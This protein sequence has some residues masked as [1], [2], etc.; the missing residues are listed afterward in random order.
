MQSEVIESRLTDA[1]GRV[2]YPM[3]CR[4]TGNSSVRVVLATGEESLIEPLPCALPPTTTTAPPT[5]PPTVAPE[6]VPVDTVPAVTI[7][8]V[9]VVSTSLP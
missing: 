6:P 1:N 4:T 2:T 8:P 7:P 3:V 5:L 9:P